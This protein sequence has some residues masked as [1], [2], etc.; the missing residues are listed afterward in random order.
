MVFSRFFF[1]VLLVMCLACAVQTAHAEEPLQFHYD[2]EPFSFLLKEELK[3]QKNSAIWAKADLNDDCFPEAIVKNQD[4]TPKNLCLH[5][6]LV[7]TAGHDIVTLG[8]FQAW[9]IVLG[10]DYNAGIRNLHVFD[11]VQNDFDYTVYIWNAAQ[12]AYQK[13]P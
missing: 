5:S 3:S 1:G 10:H 6:I 2:P 9:D 8:E 7:E 12:A 4:C 13:K 11:N